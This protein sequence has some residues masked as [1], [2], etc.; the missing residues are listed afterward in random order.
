MFF[1]QKKRIS[2]IAFGKKVKIKADWGLVKINALFWCFK[3][4]LNT[5]L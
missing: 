3:K 1:S 2:R 4:F 5:K